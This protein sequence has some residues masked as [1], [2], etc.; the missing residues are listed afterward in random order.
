[1]RH[2][3]SEGNVLGFKKIAFEPSFE[4][5]SKLTVKGKSQAK[6]LS[7]KFKNIKFDAIYS[8]DY[9]RAQETAKILKLERKL[10]IQITQAIRERQF[11]SW[12][13]RWDLVK[14]KIHEELKSLAEEEKMKYVF[15]D[16]ETEEHMWERFNLFLRGVAVSYPGKRV[17]VVCHANLM[18]T[19]LWKLGWAKY[20]ELPSGSVTNAAYYIIKSN[21]EEFFLEETHGINKIINA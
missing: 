10:K 8:S 15:E 7:L 9:I 19:L 3:E 5:K 21:G 18:R 14:N 17:L 20:H 11:G 16:V 12:A 1:V 6:E 13:G 2:G 4:I